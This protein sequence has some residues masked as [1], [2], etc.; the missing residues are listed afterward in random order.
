MLIDSGATLTALCW[1]TVLEASF[2]SGTSLSPIV[3]QTANGAVPANTAT[4]GSRLRY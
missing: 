2:R 4:L 3:L 1:H